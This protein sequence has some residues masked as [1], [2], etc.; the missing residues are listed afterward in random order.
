LSGCILETITYQQRRVESIIGY[1]ELPFINNDKINGKRNIHCFFGGSS[2][3]E[4]LLSE[5]IEVIDQEG[6]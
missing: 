2:R 3:R 5:K 1:Y 4:D 6:S